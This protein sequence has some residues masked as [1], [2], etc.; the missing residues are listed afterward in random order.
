M[1]FSTLSTLLVSTLTFGFTL[2]A[3]SPAPASLERRGVAT[4]E[5]A[6]SKAPNADISYPGYDAILV[7]SGE[8]CSGTEDI[9]D[10]SGLDLNVCY[11]P[12]IE[13]LSIMAYSPNGGTWDLTIYAALADCDDAVQLPNLNVCYNTLYDGD[14][15]YFSTIYFES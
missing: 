6:T 5:E 1:R 14:D 8:G 7:F 12:A 15:A 2:A 3:P 9:I 11:E 10:I 4:V 13:Y